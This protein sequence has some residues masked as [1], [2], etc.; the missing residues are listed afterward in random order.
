MSGVDF[1]GVKSRGVERTARTAVE[2][3]Y[4]SYGSVDCLM[5]RIFCGCFTN[6]IFGFPSTP[7]KS[8]LFSTASSFG[9]TNCDYI[10]GFRGH[11]YLVSGCFFCV[12]IYQK[13]GTNV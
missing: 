5:M 11:K 10:N 12:K 6:G 4:G 1:F 13:M 8:W 7:S 2:K 3:R 9:F